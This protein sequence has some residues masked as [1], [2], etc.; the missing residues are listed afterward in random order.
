MPCLKNFS[1]NGGL[2]SD[3][4]RLAQRDLIDGSR[5]L[6]LG[7]MLIMPQLHRDVTGLHV[8][9]VLA[10][11]TPQLFFLRLGCFG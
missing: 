10:L 5:S 9:V 8:D 4:C 6:A 1:Y 2:G 11:Q 3:C 7:L